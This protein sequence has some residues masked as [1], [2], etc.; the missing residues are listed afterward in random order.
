M[1]LR[2]VF[3]GTPDFAA[4]ALQALL[5]SSHEVV[6][7]Y[8]QPPRPAGRGH[9]EKKSPVHRLAE[10]HPIPVRTPRTLRDAQ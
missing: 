7:V 3:M 2:L 6:C 10:Q 1:S 4:T 8:G 5:S 9:K